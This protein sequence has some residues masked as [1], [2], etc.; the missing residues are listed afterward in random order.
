MTTGTII[1]V[2]LLLV[3]AGAGFFFA[4]CETALFALARWQVRQA[5]D[6]GGWRGRL[7]HGLLTRP[8]EL[9]AIIAFGNTFAMA[10]LVF[11]TVWSGHLMGG[12]V[13]WLV[14]GLAV[15]LV[16]E[17][18][19]KTVAV[20]APYKWALLVAPLLAGMRNS[21]RPLHGL[22]RYINHVLLRLSGAATSGSGRADGF[23]EEEYRELLELAFQQGAVARTERDIILQVIGLGRKQVRDLMRPR[24]QM[25]MVSDDASTDEMIRH[26][27]QLRMKRIP[28]YDQHSDTVVGILNARALIQNPGVDLSEV[29]EPPAFVPE[30]M[31]LLKLL[32]SL[33]RQRRSIAIVLDEFGD[34]AG[35][36]TL[37]DILNAALGEPPRT[38]LVFE[39]IGPGRWRISGAMR[40]DD[41]RHEYPQL[42]EVRHA[43]TMGGLLMWLLGAIPGSGQSAIYCGL[44]LTALVTDER[45]VKELLVE[46]IQ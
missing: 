18:V 40:V 6:N 24:I 28:L 46:V 30:T 33:Q 9:L 11:V 3:F 10:G 14:L 7:V 42:G 20:R 41:F 19:P 45:S 37:D 22:A 29:I 32:R 44:K 17:V 43:E 27:K 39:R 21:M 36:I 1:A 35:Y 13:E 8:E 5:R 26:A 23:T 4:L 31:S 15:L 12:I 25:P 38:R 16:C 2:V 34:M